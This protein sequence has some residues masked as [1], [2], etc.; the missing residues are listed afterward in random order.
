MKPP[1]PSDLYAAFEATWPPAQRIELGPFTYRDGAGGGSRVSAAT[2]DDDLTDAAL[3][4]IEARFS[5]DNRP[6]LFQ[7]RAGQ[8][9]FDECLDA[10]AYTLFDPVTCLLAPLD[11]LPAAS[12]EDGYV[13]WPP[14][15]MQRDIWAEDGI[16]PARLAV[17]D[18][19]S[20][21]KCSILGRL[22]DAPAATAFVATKGE[23]AALHALVVSKPYRRNGLGRAMVALAAD[24]ARAQGATYLALQV[25]TANTAALSLYQALGLEPVTGYHYRT[26]DSV[27]AT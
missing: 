20:G 16:G 19:V 7:V 21:P 5:A 18:R 8:E 14:V 12:P 17:M 11:R 13:A 1:E 3:D 22:G 9:A 23:I 24:W 6:A 25:T 10:R 2:L 27:E 26:R 4:Q 15:A